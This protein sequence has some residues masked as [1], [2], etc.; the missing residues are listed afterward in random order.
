MRVAS[1]RPDLSGADALLRDE[2]ELAPSP[3]VTPSGRDHSGRQMSAS[4]MDSP[5]LAELPLAPFL[6]RVR[7]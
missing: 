4:L 7:H 6:T 1:R 3:I 5:G 2:G